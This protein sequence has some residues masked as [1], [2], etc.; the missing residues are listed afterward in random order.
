MLLDFSQQLLFKTNGIYKSIP[1]IYNLDCN[2]D[3]RTEQ[4]RPSKAGLFFLCISGENHLMAHGPW[5][6]QLQNQIA[7]K[8]FMIKCLFK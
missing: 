2:L 4:T 5:K 7:G 8:D 1:D 6:L 3:P